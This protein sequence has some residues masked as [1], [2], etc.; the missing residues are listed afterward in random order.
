M[1]AQTYSRL[2]GMIFAVIAVLHLI[3]A[4]KGAEATLDGMTIPVGA[5]W[6]G[7]L[8]SG[9]LAWLGFTAPRD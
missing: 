2:A 5:S 4:L 3:R 7:L 6:I 9:T 1:N 8:V